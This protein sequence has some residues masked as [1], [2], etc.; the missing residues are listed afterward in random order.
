MATKKRKALT[1]TPFRRAMY[2]RGQGAYD[3]LAQL[4]GIPK[5]RWYNVAYGRALVPREH[6]EEVARFADISVW[7]LPFQHVPEM[8][9]V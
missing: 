9:E 6:L 1:M 4:T 7:D 3:D 5:A 2:R 8:V